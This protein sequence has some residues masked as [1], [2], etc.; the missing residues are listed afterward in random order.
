M[1]KD[2]HLQIKE[3]LLNTKGY[4][5]LE[6]LMA[7]GIGLIVL[8]AV[9][10][11]YTGSLKI[12]KDIKS[13]SDNIHTKMPSVELISRYF[14]RWGVGVVSKKRIRFNGTDEPVMPSCTECPEYNKMI[15]ITSGNTCDTIEFYGNLYGTGF[16]QS[17]SGTT[18]NIISCR[19][20]RSYSQNCYTIWR[21]T[22]P[23][24]DL[25][26]GNILPIELPP[27]N[28]PGV[29]DCL[30]RTTW[31]NQN[32]NVTTAATMS[33]LTVQAG[34][35]IHRLPHKIRLYCKSN[36][37]DANKTWL[38]V[39]LEDQSA[40]YCTD[41]ESASPI[42]P[43]DEFKV[44]EQYPEGCIPENGNCNALKMR[45]KFRSYSPKHRGGFDTYVVEKV[46]GR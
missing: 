24:N 22:F 44:I 28:P 23:I 32:F 33:G 29:I 39:D 21:N 1:T 38:Y 18:A 45:I 19:L 17:V 9:A 46:F 12:F 36:A 27:L 6:M 25:S 34:D 15:T 31:Q 10:A 2:R 16:V 26:A 3:R 4:S 42:A 7:I 37:Q 41:N 13:I 8:G 11:S 35:Y 5:V 40:G 14:D 43:V 30:D 20:S